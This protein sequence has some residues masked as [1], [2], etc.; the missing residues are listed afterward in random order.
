MKTRILVTV[1]PVTIIAMTAL[2]IISVQ[3]GSKNINSAISAQMEA[4]LQVQGNKVTNY[5]TKIIDIFPF[6]HKSVL[7]F[8]SVSPPPAVLPLPSGTAP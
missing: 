8:F 5:F 2:T 1:L 3:Y 4:E 7:L 6:P